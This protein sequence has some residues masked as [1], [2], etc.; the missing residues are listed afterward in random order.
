[1][2]KEIKQSRKAED[3]R[4]IADKMFQAM[5]WNMLEAIKWNIMRL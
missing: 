1:M 5:K 3:Y 2:I 4:V